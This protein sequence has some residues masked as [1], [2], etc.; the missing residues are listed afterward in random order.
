MFLYRVSITLWCLH[1]PPAQ[2]GKDQAFSTP[3]RGCHA[4]SGQ[5]K[6]HTGEWHLVCGSRAE[7][8]AACQGREAWRHLPRESQHPWGCCREAVR[9]QQPGASANRGPG[10]SRLWFLVYGRTFA[11]V[12][13]IPSCIHRRKKRGDLSSQSEQENVNMPHSLV[14]ADIMNTETMVTLWR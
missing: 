1:L 3:T 5:G 7:L 2:L 11:W 12:T 6:H 9:E 13:G 8:L 10:L 4:L 14:N